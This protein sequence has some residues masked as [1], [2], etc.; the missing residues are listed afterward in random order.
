MRFLYVGSNDLYYILVCI[1]QKAK[2]A[3]QFEAREDTPRQTG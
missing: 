2:T 3:N 1:Q